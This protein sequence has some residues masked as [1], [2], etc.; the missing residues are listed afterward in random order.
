MQQCIVPRFR[1][2]AGVSSVNL[3]PF[4]VHLERP[5]VGEVSAERLR[6][7][8]EG[9]QE[10]FRIAPMLGIASQIGPLQVADRCHPSK[11]LDSVRS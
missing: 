3:Q 8:A 7:V 2:V 4:K 6:E 10:E 5:S 1:E 11:H 9:A